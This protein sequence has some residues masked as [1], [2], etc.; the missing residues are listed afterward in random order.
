MTKTKLCGITRK[1]DIAVLARIRPEYMGFVFAKGSKRAVT[2]ETALELK[3]GLHEDI[4]AVGVFVNEDPREI[5]RLFRRGIIDVAQLHGRED[6]DYIER[7]RSLT[8]I[9]I[10]QA[11]SVKTGEDILRAAK[12]SAEYVLLD[13]EGGGSGISFDRS[14]AKGLRRPYFLAGGLT[15]ETVA[16]AIDC[17]RPYGVDVSSGIETEGKKD[18]AKMYAFVRAV[19]ERGRENEG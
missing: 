14:L 8:D 4:T 19:R 5:V 16:E 1:E 11:F 13:S 18:S 9:A 2:P 15:P 17:L 6:E 12:S 3:R 7:L 10:I